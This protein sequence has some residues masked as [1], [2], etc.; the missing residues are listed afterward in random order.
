[1][2]FCRIVAVFFSP[3]V[4]FFSQKNVAV[5]QNLTDSLRRG[6]DNQSCAILAVSLGGIWITPMVNTSVQE[7]GAPKQHTQH[8]GE[9]GAPHRA[10]AFV[11]M[12]SRERCQ[13]VTTHMPSITTG[14]LQ[15]QPDTQREGPAEHCLDQKAPE[16][17]PRGRAE[18]GERG[19]EKARQA[20]PTQSNKTQSRTEQPRKTYQPRRSTQENKRPNLSG[21]QAKNET[22]RK[23][24][25]EYKCTCP[26]YGQT[27]KYKSGQIR[28]WK[29]RNRCKNA[30]VQAAG[31]SSNNLF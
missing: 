30:P 22:G 31:M 2:Y 28:I 6:Q 25:K 18:Q 9:G 10:E 12:K 27:H 5:F 8:G 15:V 21:D 7:G 3:Q 13:A 23:R 1:M 17:K 11:A 19:K 24:I 26:V 14:P 20:D 4:F 16:D 29:D